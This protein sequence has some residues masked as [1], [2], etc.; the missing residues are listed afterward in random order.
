M[1]RTYE[2][3]KDTECRGN[4]AKFILDITP[5]QLGA[6][7][8]IRPTNHHHRVTSESHW[9]AT[10]PGGYFHHTQQGGR[11]SFAAKN[12]RR[13]GRM[14]SVCDVPPPLVLLMGGNS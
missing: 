3:R 1:L 2:V 10:S 11:R 7:G 6:A 5:Q 14:F 12:E 8:R 13:D 4:C 9:R